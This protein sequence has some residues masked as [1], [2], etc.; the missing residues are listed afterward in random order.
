[1]HS[2]LDTVVEET[3]GTHNLSIKQAE[4]I[5]RTLLDHLKF[6]QYCFIA[7]LFAENPEQSDITAPAYLDIIEKEG[8]T[9][10]LHDVVCHFKSANCSDLII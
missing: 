9:F 3:D 7:F 4:F 2:N 5:H 1:M 8:E 6:N 10:L